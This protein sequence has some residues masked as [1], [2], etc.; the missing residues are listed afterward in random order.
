[1]RPDER[2]QKLDLLERKKRNLPTYVNEFL[3]YLDSND[4][5][6]NTL[7]GY[8]RDIDCFIDW[9]IAEGFHKGDRKDISLNL[10]ETLMLKDM[11]TFQ[12]HCKNQ[13]GNS[14]NTVARKLASLKSLFHYLSQIAEDDDLYPYLKRNVMAKVKIPKEKVSDKKKAERIANSILVDDEFQDF[15]L[16]VSEGFGELIKNHKRLYSYYL[17]NR[18]RDMAIISLMLG[19]GLRAAEALNI[20]V[21]DIDWNNR[22]VFVTRKG[23]SQ[24]V[25]SFSEIAAADMEW[26]ASLRKLHYPK[27]KNNEKAF[28]LSMATNTG[29]CSRWKLRSL[30]RRFEQYIR[31]YKKNTLTVHKL[32]HS[33]ATRHYEENK[34]IAMLKEIMNHSDINTTMVYT[35]IRNDA[36]AESVNRTDK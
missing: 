27:V 19:S 6:P 15:R 20:N 35:H 10:L 32:R 26:Y 7:L 16:F 29:E 21:N 34:D 11:M 4:A 22:K 3:E 5:S 24:D 30:Q 14:T 18:A 25:V 17:T 13:L 36:I 8:T 9:L 1:M 12:N 23:N 28:F 31:F 2:K 33:F